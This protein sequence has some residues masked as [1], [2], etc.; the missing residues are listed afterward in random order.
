MT[1]GETRTEQGGSAAPLTPPPSPSDAPSGSIKPDASE[2][3]GA[4][5]S[6]GGEGGE[7]TRKRARGDEEGAAHP[8][9]RPLGGGEGSARGGNLFVRLGAALQDGK[10]RVEEGKDGGE[11]VEALLSPFL[12]TTDLLRLSCAG[13][14]VL[15]FRFY[16][17]PEVHV[18]PPPPPATKPGA[19][20]P[21]PL[22]P[23]P[24]VLSLLERQRGEGARVV[25]LRVSVKSDE[26][27]PVLPPMLHALAQGRMLPRLQ[28]LNLSGAK[29]L[30]D[31]LVELVGVVLRSGRVRGLRELELA[32]LGLGL[33]GVQVRRRGRRAFVGV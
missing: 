30:G 16:L 13:R 11:V 26:A 5:D 17:G 28:R 4:P 6:R 20:P 24:P 9:A 8:P 10:R 22:R 25:G 12:S 31:R 23:P 27:R 15:A 3:A 7:E 14:S 2:R 18:R 21:P 19:A 29:G 1:A 32:S 33:K